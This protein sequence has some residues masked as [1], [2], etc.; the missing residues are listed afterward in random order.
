LKVRS[1]GTKIFSIDRFDGKVLSAQQ[2]DSRDYTKFYRDGVKIISLYE[3]PSTLIAKDDTGQVLWQLE[4]YMNYWPLF[5][6]GDNILTSS[7]SRSLARMNYRTGQV[8]WEV[9]S[10]FV[11][12]Y[13]LLD[14]KV[15]VLKSEGKLA[16]LDVN[17]GQEIGNVQFNR[18]F[19]DAWGEAS[20]FV[21]AQSPYVVVYFGDTQEL[22]AFKF[23]TQ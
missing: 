16:A 7:D 20:F 3:S 5:L 1:D 4:R 2:R 11:S 15:F 12:N 22:V 19:S 9:W 14:G 13:V 21:A 23:E 10:L 18:G 17:S 6:E 8:V